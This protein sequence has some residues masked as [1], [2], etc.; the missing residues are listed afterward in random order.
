MLLL[1]RCVLLIKWLSS[2]IGMLA[3]KYP[4]EEDRDRNTF[5]GFFCIHV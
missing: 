2:P 1:G 3:V 4:V 5:L